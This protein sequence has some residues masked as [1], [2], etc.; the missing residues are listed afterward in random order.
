MG[1]DSEDFVQGGWRTEGDEAEPS[2]PLKYKTYNLSVNNMLNK[3]RLI[4]VNKSMYVKLCD[5]LEFRF[6]RTT[7][8]TS[9]TPR[10]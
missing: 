5:T 9:T 6:I 10:Y 3:L 8:L 1:G 2:A 4:K 7:N